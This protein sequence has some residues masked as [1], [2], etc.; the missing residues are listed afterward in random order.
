MDL[1]GGAVGLSLGR[2]GPGEKARAGWSG[3][4]GAAVGRSGGSGSGISLPWDHSYSAHHAPSHV[5]S[6][7]E[8]SVRQPSNMITLRIR[9]SDG[10]RRL[11]VPADALLSTLSQRVRHLLAAYP[12]SSP[13]VYTDRHANRLPRSIQSSPMYSRGRISSYGAMAIPHG[14]TSSP[15]LTAASRLQR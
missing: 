7:K 4:T 3:R 13:S 8:C 15:G 11:T 6:S 5:F 9:S 1:F 10:T 2:G 12:S 14:D